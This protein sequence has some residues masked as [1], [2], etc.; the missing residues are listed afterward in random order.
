MLL[1]NDD[2]LFMQKALRQA[3]KALSCGE[4]PVGAVIVKD[5]KLISSGYNR[6]IKDRDPSAHAEM[7]A[8]R[9][10]AKKLNNYRL[11]GCILY[12]TLEPC[13]MCAGVLINARIEKIVYGAKDKKAGACGSVFKIA[14]GAKLNHRIKIE[15][16]DEKLSAQCANMLTDF[17][18]SKRKGGE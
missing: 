17:F 8:V 11:N 18:K 16:A 14:D 1:K 2:V 3:Q 5:G 13:A 10:A 15:K 6:C 9:K 4:V 7:I 12:V